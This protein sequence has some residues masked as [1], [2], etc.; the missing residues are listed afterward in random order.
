[1]TR[2]KSCPPYLPIGRALL[3]F[4]YPLVH[5]EHP[6]NVQLDAV[7][8]TADDSPY[9]EQASLAGLTDLKRKHRLYS[10]PCL[11]LSQ[12][13]LNTCHRPSPRWPPAPAPLQRHTGKALPLLPHSRPGPQGCELVKY[14]FPSAMLLP[15][16]VSCPPSDHCLHLHNLPRKVQNAASR[17]SKEAPQSCGGPLS[18]GPRSW[19]TLCPLQM[20][21]L[22]VSKAL[23]SLQPPLL[24]VELEPDQPLF[25]GQVKRRR[26]GKQS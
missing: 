11:T 23:L 8:V 1:M 9:P 3:R 21:P 12:K 26:R 2:N 10:T 5:V 24:L 18:D 20:P 13:A 14:P 25:L 17:S 15:S 22:L 6:G 4:G 16:G 19:C 7:Q